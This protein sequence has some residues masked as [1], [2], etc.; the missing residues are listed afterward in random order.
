MPLPP[1]AKANDS[2]ERPWAAAR[3]DS[4]QWLVERYWWW[5]RRS[6]AFIGHG[7]VRARTY[8]RGIA[9][10]M[11]TLQLIFDLSNSLVRACCERPPRFVLVS[12]FVSTVTVL[13]VL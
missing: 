9:V 5:L 8:V 11:G 1:K 4:R 6:A 2:R 10:L 12:R 7:I 13:E 3:G